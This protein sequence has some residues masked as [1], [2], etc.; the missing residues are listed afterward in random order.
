M[1]MPPPKVFLPRQ[2]AIQARAS[3]AAEEEDEAGRRGC[4]R[5]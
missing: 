3:A 5:K 4:G 1:F 2:A